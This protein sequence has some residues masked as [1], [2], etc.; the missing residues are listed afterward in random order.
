MVHR[1]WHAFAGLRDIWIIKDNIWIIKDDNG[2]I[3]LC[4]WYGCK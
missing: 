1:V 3:R 4:Q 2:V